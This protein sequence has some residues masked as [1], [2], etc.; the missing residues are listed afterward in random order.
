MFQIFSPV[1]YGSFVMA[2]SVS[3]MFLITYL[4]LFPRDYF[5]I[6]I[7]ML[8]PLSCIG[9]EFVFAWTVCWFASPVQSLAKS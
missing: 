2:D 7:Y 8:I 3:N 6:V 5:Y 4:S 9:C 1:F